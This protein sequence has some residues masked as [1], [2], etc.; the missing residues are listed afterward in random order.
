MEKSSKEEILQ[1]IQKLFALGNK[2]DN[3]HQAAAAISKAQELLDKYNLSMVDVDGIR[4]KSVINEFE[5]V[6]QSRFQGWEIHLFSKLARVM[7]CYPLTSRRSRDGKRVHIL[8]VVGFP[9]DVEVYKYTYMYLRRVISDIGNEGLATHQK[10]QGYKDVRDSYDFKLAFCRGASDR[11]T[12]RVRDDREGRMQ[13]DEKCRALVV[14]NMT[15]VS[16]F[17]RT[18]MK[19]SRGRGYSLRGG[20]G[21]SQGREAANGIALRRGVSGSGSKRTAIGG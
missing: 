20:N 19:L 16:T 9:E 12:E 8:K 11:I 7:D 1:K 4:T 5:T 6:V 18:Q 13:V 10:E 21:Y 14:S 3:E 2:N 17:V 15:A